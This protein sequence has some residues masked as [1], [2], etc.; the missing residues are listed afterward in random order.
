MFLVQRKRAALFACLSATAS[1]R[2]V[3]CAVATLLGAAE[4]H[5]HVHE[6]GHPQKARE[7]R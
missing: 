6:Q 1:S 7:P 2:S 5:E 3:S 4:D